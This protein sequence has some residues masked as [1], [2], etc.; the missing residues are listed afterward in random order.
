LLAK[1]PEAKFVPQAVDKVGP[2]VGAQIL[3]SAIISGLLALFVILVYVA[4][5]YEFS[6]AVGAVIAILH[7]VLMTMGWFFLTGRQLNAPIV[8]AILTIIGFS[9]NDTIVI[10]DR[11]REDLKLGIKGSFKE[12]I[13]RALNQTL[14]RTI[15]TS[16]TVFLSTLSLYL[17]GGS[18]INDFAFTFLVGILTGTYS[19]IYIASALVLWWHRGERPKA[20]SQVVMDNTVVARA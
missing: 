6:F 7:D 13:N 12:I 19:S 4:M 10:F 1:F 9:I 3:K 16:G 15:I 14:S 18:V 8:A 20:A 17:F 5:R 11:I 2:V